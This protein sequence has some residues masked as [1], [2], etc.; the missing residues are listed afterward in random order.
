[1]TALISKF[2]NN[3][4]GDTLVEVLL[5]TVIFSIVIS[6]SFAL[7]NRSSRI[8]QVSSERSEAASLMQ[9]Q[10]E[11]LRLYRDLG[12]ANP[13]WDLIQTEKVQSTS[14]TTNNCFNFLDGVDASPSQSA[15]FF[16]D[17]DS[18]R[19]DFSPILANGNF[20]RYYI[21][22]EGYSSGDTVNDDLVDFY[23]HACWQGPGGTGPQQ[24]SLVYRL[25]L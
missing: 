12:D 10:A 9:T 23:V 20:D 14:P 11:T 3:Q 1:M 6:A 16:F 22:I 2:K 17:E 13:V 4:R 19:Q 5:A 21:W 24:A 7:V 8:N 15:S 25:T 18:N